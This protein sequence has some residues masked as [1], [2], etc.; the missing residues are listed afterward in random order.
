[1]WAEESEKASMFCMFYLETHANLALIAR[2]HKSQREE[3]RGKR[4]RD[5]GEKERGKRE[6]EKKRKKERAWGIFF[7][8]LD[9]AHF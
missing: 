3:G 5:R 7:N 2:L 1:V 8:I 9:K 4:E 6:R